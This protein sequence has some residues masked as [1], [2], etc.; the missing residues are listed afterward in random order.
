MLNMLI[1]NNDI[2]YVKNLINFVIGKHSYIKITDIASNSFEIL[3]MVNKNDNIDLILLDLNISEL[4]PIEI[5]DAIYKA[6]SRNVPSVLVLSD[7]S[8]LSAEILNHPIVMDYINKSDDMINIYYKLM[9]FEY[10]KKYCDIDENIIKKITSE[11]SYIGYNPAHLGT[12][13]IKECI[14]E[15][16]KTKNFELIYNLE[17]QLYKKIAFAHNKSSQNI[18]A[19]IIK[20]TN[21]MYLESD[22]SLLKEYF[23]FCDERK[24]PT[25]KMVISTILNRL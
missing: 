18:K 7:E 23:C 16:Y 8:Q 5:L 1:A 19:N 24:K 9:N 2:D 4:N 21:Y 20:A 12:Q 11:L 17:N 13:Y 6:N 25:P 3:D 22:M 15:I 14:I 10:I